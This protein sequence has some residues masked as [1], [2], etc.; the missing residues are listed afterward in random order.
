[1]NEH[2]HWEPR[3]RAGHKQKAELGCDPRA[4]VTVP[5]LPPPPTVVMAGWSPWA[6][7]PMGAGG[8]RL[9]TEKKLGTKPASP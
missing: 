6:D 1:M 5:A 4:D 7:A 8:Q 9:G 3:L 2:V